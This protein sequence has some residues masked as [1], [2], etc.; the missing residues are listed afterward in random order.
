[1]FS[2]THARVIEART[3]ASLRVIDTVGFAIGVAC[4]MICLSFGG[5][6]PVG[7]TL[8]HPFRRVK[9]ILQSFCN[10]FCGVAHT[11]RMLY[12]NIRMLN[13]NQNAISI[14]KSTRIFL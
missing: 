2:L 12:T 5:F 10:Y 14:K 7:R 1:M 8:P 6:C 4:V 3:A 13:T 11:I 9:T